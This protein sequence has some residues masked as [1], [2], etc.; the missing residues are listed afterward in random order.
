MA[1]TALRIGILGAG[2]IATW[3]AD[4]IRATDGLALA[5]VCDRSAAAAVEWPKNAGLRS[6][7][8]LKR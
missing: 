2:Y 6:I 3:H 7:P 1:V 4:A 8:I 5:A